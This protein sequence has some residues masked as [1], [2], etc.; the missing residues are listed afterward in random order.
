[1]PAL[2]P[3]DNHD[4]RLEDVVTVSGWQSITW[5]VAGA[6]GAA[7]FLTLVA[8]AVECARKALYGLEIR[9]RRALKERSEAL[10]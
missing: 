10:S 1:M 7:L 8:H 2:L 4:E 5:G 6:A 9:E 3:A